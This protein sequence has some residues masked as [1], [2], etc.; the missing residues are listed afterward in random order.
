M[1]KMF[2]IRMNQK[3]SVA[4]ISQKLQMMA[5]AHRGRKQLPGLYLQKRSD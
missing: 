4:R 3:A 1:T 5:H 2:S